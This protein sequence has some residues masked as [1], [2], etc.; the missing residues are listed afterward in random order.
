MRLSPEVQRLL[1]SGEG[2]LEDEL[3]VVD[4]DDDETEAEVDE[5]IEEPDFHSASPQPKAN[6]RFS[7]RYL[8]FTLLLLHTLP[9]AMATDALCVRACVQG[10]DA[11]V[12]PAVWRSC[13]IA[14]ATRDAT[15]SCRSRAEA[16]A[17]Q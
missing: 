6:P 15:L 5:Q 1:L 9:H 3:D 8:F 11:R 7:P 14:A 13:S 4:E 2:Q 10:V 12:P 17:A 16:P